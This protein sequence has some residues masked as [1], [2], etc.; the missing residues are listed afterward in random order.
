MLNSHIA[1]NDKTQQVGCVLLVSTLDDYPLN[2]DYEY[3]RLQLQ[4]ISCTPIRLVAIYILAVSPSPSPSSSSST[5]SSPS[6]S[7]T[8]GGG[9]SE[10]SGTTTSS[11]DNNK[12]TNLVGWNNAIDFATYIM[13]KTLRLRMRCIRGTPMECRYQLMCLG[14]TTN[15][16]PRELLEEEEKEEENEGDN[17][18]DQKR[19]GRGSNTADDERNKMNKKRKVA[20]VAVGNGHQLQRGPQGTAVVLDDDEPT[21]AT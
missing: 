19:E 10:T 4:L 16:L 7:T 14:F 9:G 3:L 20:A 2:M 12:K 1:K 17:E 13:G 21:K 11:N 6:N 8:L 15:N 18:E 5:S